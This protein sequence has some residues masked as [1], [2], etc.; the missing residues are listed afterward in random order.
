MTRRRRA[1]AIRRSERGSAGRASRRSSSSEASARSC[2]SSTV[3]RG[4]RAQDAAG[5]RTLVY[6]AYDWEEPLPAPHRAERGRAL[7]LLPALTCAHSGRSLT[8]T[9]PESS[10]W[11]I[12][13][14]SG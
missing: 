7:E 1:A 10:S 4:E 2:T 3:E 9:S 14:R 11:K 5:A 6:D 8:T 12:G 13:Y